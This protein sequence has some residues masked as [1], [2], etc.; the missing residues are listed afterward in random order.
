[1]VYLNMIEFGGQPL[2][3][4]PTL[5]TYK[6][7]DQLD[8]VLVIKCHRFEQTAHNLLSLLAQYNALKGFPSVPC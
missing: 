3:L 7:Y 4:G 6:K 8:F 1:M 2:V 5:D